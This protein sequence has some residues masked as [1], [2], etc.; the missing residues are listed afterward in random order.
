MKLSTSLYYRAKNLHF[1][2]MVIFIVKSYE[3]YLTTGKLKN[4]KNLSKSYCKMINNVLRLWSIDFSSLKRPQLDYAEQKKISKQRVDL[5]TACAIHYGLNMGMVIRYLKGEYIGASRDANAILSVVSSLISNQDCEH[6]K[7]II[8][9]GCPSQL[10]FE[11]DSDNKHQVLQRGNQ[12]TFNKYPEVT[13][14][15]MNKEEMN[16][17]VL[18]LKAWDVY[19]FPYCRPTPQGICE[20]Y[21]KCRVIFDLSRQMNL[22]EVVLNRQTR[23]DHKA[24]IDFGKAK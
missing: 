11:E 16:S 24:K 3:L 14:K 1:N 10:D 23:T 5:A 19:F 17:H 8:N 9:Q 2:N 20:K 22:D 12:K 21:G 6:I 7:R 18:A 15:V 13:T 4:L